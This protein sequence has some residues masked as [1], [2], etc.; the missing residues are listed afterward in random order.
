MASRR[1]FNLEQRRK[2]HLAR[3]QAWQK[4]S[5]DEQIAYLNQYFS[6]GAKRQRK[7]LGI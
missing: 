3:L 1:S 7:R 5:K 6:E 4:L 2:E